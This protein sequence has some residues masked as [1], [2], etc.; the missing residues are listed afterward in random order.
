MFDASLCRFRLMIA[1]N[2]QTSDGQTAAARGDIRPPWGQSRSP[3]HNERTTHQAPACNC[4]A[5]GGFPC[6]SRERDATVD[7]RWMR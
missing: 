4:I 3:L 7:L 2:S 1:Q 6:Q 5:R